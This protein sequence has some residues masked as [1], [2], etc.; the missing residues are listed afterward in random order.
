MNITSTELLDRI[1]EITNKS[2]QK[3]ILLVLN[4]AKIPLLILFTCIILS[5][6]FV[7]KCISLLNTTNSENNNVTKL[8]INKVNKPITNSYI[9]V[10]LSG[11]VN[12]A[13]TYRILSGTRLFELI[14]LAGG[15][16]LDADKAFVSR[17]Y[18]LS[19]ILNDQQKVHIP[20]IYEVRDGI[21]IE[22]TKLINLSNSYATSDSIGS[23]SK[24]TSSQGTIISI[25]NASTE[26]LKMLPGIGDVTAARIMAARPYETIQQLV[27][28]GVIKQTL[29]D[30]ISSQLEL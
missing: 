2:S 28:K 4:K 16:G 25:N 15:L 26:M 17:N 7:Y 23:N 13:K 27:D 22:N 8:A 6:I 29:L 10:D 5:T 9:Y 3:D 11:S 12:K 18:N 1:K 30:K 21:F 24:V 19:V 14:E 20:S